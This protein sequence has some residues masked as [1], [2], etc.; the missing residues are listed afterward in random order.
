MNLTVPFEVL[1]HSPAGFDYPT[2]S[3]CDLIPQYE[4]AMRRECLGK[5][6]W[7]FLVSKLNPYPETWTEW[8]ASVEYS[9]GDVVVRNLCTYISTANTNTTDPLATGSSWDKFER[10][11]HAGANKLWTGYLRQIMAYKVFVAS[12]TTTTYRSGAGGMTINVGDGTGVRAV[13]K[14]EFLTNLTQYNG[15]IEMTTVNMNEWL[16]DNYETEGLP[17]P[18]CVGNCDVPINR[19][20]RIAFR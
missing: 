14:Q 2:D 6:L 12:L 20:R 15:I 19:S 7:D 4:Q 11:N 3:F 5:P 1:Q 16:R 17:L 13:N 18:A 10:F 8:D 9:I